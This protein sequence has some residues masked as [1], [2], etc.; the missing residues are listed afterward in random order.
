MT[1]RGAE[2]KSRV[3]QSRTNKY[4]WRT[5]T[6]KKQR[7]ITRHNGCLKASRQKRDQRK[8]GMRTARAEGSRSRKDATEH[9]SRGATSEEKGRVEN[10][11]NESKAC[12]CVTL[13]QTSMSVH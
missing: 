7:T 2:A 13:L 10:I 5:Q 11:T 8:Q 9:C 6:S 4:G 12:T 1:P 3:E